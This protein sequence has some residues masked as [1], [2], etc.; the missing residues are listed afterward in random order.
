MPSFIQQ[1][2]LMNR[3]AGFQLGEAGKMFQISFGGSI[4]VLFLVAVGNKDG[5]GRKGGVEV[6]GE[7]FLCHSRW[8]N[9][10]AR[11]CSLV[12]QNLFHCMLEA[13]LC[14]SLLLKCVFYLEE[15]LVQT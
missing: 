13:E 3:L 10:K 5:G 1:D 6:A 11:N 2:Y 9:S 7:M 4:K 15:R 12:R 14:G 8:V